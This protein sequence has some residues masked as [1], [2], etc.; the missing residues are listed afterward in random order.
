M[1]FVFHCRAFRL[2]NNM[3]Q[4]NIPENPTLLTRQSVKF[5]GKDEEISDVEMDTAFIRGKRLPSTESTRPSFAG[6]LFQEQLSERQ[7]IAKR[8]AKVK[9]SSPLT[10]ARELQRQ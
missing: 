4:V 7:Q 3:T 8:P 6:Q 2:L 10:F 5:K 1:R 9:W